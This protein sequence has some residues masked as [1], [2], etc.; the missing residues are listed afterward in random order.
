MPRILIAGCGYVGQAA[1]DLFCDAGWKVEGWTLSA[2]SAAKLTGK[3]YPVYAIPLQAGI[4]IGTLL[5]C[6]ELCIMLGI[7]LFV[8]GSYA[9]PCFIGT[10]TATQC[11]RNER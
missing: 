10:V 6:V 4:S 5:I 3:P 8:P 11:H 2:K 1:A 7:L 9:G